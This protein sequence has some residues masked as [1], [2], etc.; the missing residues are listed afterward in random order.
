MSRAELATF[1]RELATALEA[2]LPLMS[3]LR[4]VAHQGSSSRQ[5][6]IVEHLMDRIEAGRSLAHA[7]AEWGAPF[8]DM[9]VGM[10]RA[11][12]ASGRLDAVMLQL[13]DLL[14]RDADVR[15]AVLGAM[16]YPAI[17]T[18]ILSIGIIIIVTVTIP[19]VLTVAGPDA[20]LP[21]PTRI[22]QGF[23]EVIGSYWYIMLGLGLVATLG[24]KAAMAKPI[25]K[26][27]VHG[28]LLR[29]PV[30][31]PLLRDVAVGRFT[32]TL[33][34]LLKSG[35]PVIDALS[36]T[37]NT[38]GNKAMERVIDDVVEEVRTGKSIADPLEASG[39][40]PPLLIQI[41]GLGER[42]GRL[43]EMLSHA[44]NSLDRK[45]KASIELFTALLPPV[46]LVVMASLVG[47]IM[48][49]AILPLM[50]MQ[51]AIG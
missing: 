18:V 13:A 3:A 1:V 47:F 30:A 49:A 25:F 41:V 37:R 4:A 11:G 8:D 24:W 6:A 31:G 44:A 9:V 26:L 12:E 2:G 38:L 36:I 32:R 43:D 14:D 46:I 51:S 22:V 33:G 39:H 29:I 35:L 28:L 27:R 23:A 48:A 21:L 42:T 7:A 45:T 34:T 19:R 10:L 17:L 40:F 5:Q 50:T 20:Q 16:V 15:R